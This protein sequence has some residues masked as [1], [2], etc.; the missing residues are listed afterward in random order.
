MDSAE[1]DMNI[2]QNVSNIFDIAD[3]VVE[4]VTLCIALIKSS[5]ISRHSD[6]NP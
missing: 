6:E 5:E 2:L 3:F 4:N 1:L